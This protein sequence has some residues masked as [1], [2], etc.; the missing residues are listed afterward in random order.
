MKRLDKLL[1][2]AQ[3]I[4]DISYIDYDYSKLADAELYELIR[5][6]IT[7]QRME[8]ILEPVRFVSHDPNSLRMKVS[9]L[10]EEEQY[11]MC[12]RYGRIICNELTN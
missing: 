3:S 9:R 6:D 8:E 2:A 12:D 4:E 5:E 7:P 10:A 1:L 11:E